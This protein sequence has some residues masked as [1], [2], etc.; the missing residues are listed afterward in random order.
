MN[1][2]KLMYKNNLTYKILLIV[3]SS[4]LILFT[5]SFYQQT[6]NNDLYLQLLATE[7]IIENFDFS[8]VSP[9]P[10]GISL[11]S[12][13]FIYFNID[14]I[15]ILN[16]ISPIIIVIIFILLTHILK[17]LGETEAVL[18]SFY[19][20]THLFFLKSFNQ[21]NAEII[22]FLF[23][24]ITLY[25]TYLIIFSNSK[26]NKLFI[27]LFILSLIT[28][29]VRDAFF[30]IILSCYVYIY[31]TYYI[32]NHDKKS[33]FII[34]STFIPL[35]FPML[36]RTFHNNQSGGLSLLLEDG[37]E[38]RIFLFFDTFISIYKI[39]P[40]LIFPKLNYFNSNLNLSLYISIIII[41]ILLNLLYYRKRKYDFDGKPY[42]LIQL[43]F[44]TA[45]IYFLFLSISA[46]ILDYK[47][48]NLYRVAGVSLFF[49]G[50]GFWILVL[51]LIRFN[52]KLKYIILFFI[53]IISQL[54]FLYAVRYEYRSKNVRFL[55]G[56]HYKIANKL[57]NSIQDIIDREIKIHIF[58]GGGWQGRNLFSLL[59][60]NLMINNKK[61]LELIEQEAHEP[62]NNLL[63]SRV[64]YDLY[65]EDIEF[66]RVN[67]LFEDQ[68]V[69]LTKIKN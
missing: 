62:L 44:S 23:M 22:A 1:F 4:E 69:F 36:Y 38:N 40:E 31:F 43:F 37:I 64:D 50:V 20:C 55:Y 49:L 35:I 59:K 18:I 39:L 32:K 42:R 41:F 66:F 11:V 53:L 68:V 46:G 16:W 57:N 10:I 19:S 3:F 21:F 56:N 5:F 28:I 54:K 2:L 29:S 58:T 14:P 12:S 60:Y 9:H 65:F 48:G 63:I 61:N 8:D 51:D 7:K 15:I 52:K 47:W 30:F 6:A 27:Y 13:F 34:I 45:L 24:I 67:K 26:N 17:C 33:Q 25:I